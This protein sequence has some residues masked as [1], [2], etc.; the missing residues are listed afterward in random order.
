M[1]VCACVCVCVCVCVCACVR[2]CMCMITE[3]VWSQQLRKLDS[4]YLRRLGN[5]LPRVLEQSRAEST[6]KKYRAAAK[7]WQSW[8][9]QHQ[10][11]PYPADPLHVALYLIERMQDATSPSSVTAAAYG[12]SWQHTMAGWPDPVHTLLISR[13]LQSARRQL[14]QPIQRKKPITKAILKRIG[15]NLCGSERLQDRLVLVVLFLGFSGILRWSDMSCIC[16]DDV[17]FRRDYMA[18]FIAK[19][20]NDQMRKGHWVFVKRWKGQLCPVKFTERLIHCGGLV[21]KAKLL[22][23]VRGSGA[24]QYISGKMTY[25]RARELIRAVLVQAGVNASEYGLHSLR[26]GG[27]SIAIAAGLPDRLVKRQGGWKSDSAM[28]N[29]FQESLPSLLR[30]SEALDVES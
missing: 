8:A 6:V 29:Y 14:S 27:A 11:Q 18:V 26:S 3:N 23:R 24:N 5:Q 17:L 10:L 21:G 7:R 1:C 9:H 4:S 12:I 2:A 19:R 15:V 30:V 20:K 28:V 16:A 22:G 25:S 13:V